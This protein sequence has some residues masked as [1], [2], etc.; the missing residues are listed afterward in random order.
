MSARK[1]AAL[2]CAFIIDLNTAVLAQ[3]PTRPD[4]KPVPQEQEVEKIVTGTNEV[5][6][7]AVVRDKKGHFIKD[8]RQS[9]FEVYEDGV[10]QTIKSFRIVNREPVQTSTNAP[11]NGPGETAASVQPPAPVVANSNRLGAVALVFDR[12]GPEASGAGASGI[13]SNSIARRLA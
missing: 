7:D 5:L 2:L 11:T 6:L 3:T 10:P 4:Q 12:L 13:A 9:D 8:L 1:F